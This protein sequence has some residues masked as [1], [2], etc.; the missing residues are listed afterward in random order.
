M[1]ECTRGGDAY[2]DAVTKVQLGRCDGLFCAMG[3]YDDCE[4]RERVDRVGGK[5][6]AV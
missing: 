3:R 5:G 4:R 6:G 2:D 1:S